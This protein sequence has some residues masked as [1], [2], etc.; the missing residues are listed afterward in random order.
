MFS[1]FDHI[2]FGNPKAFYLLVLP[3]LLIFWIAW[4]Y[5]KQYA[6]LRMSSLD[7]FSA[8]GSYKGGIKTALY[9]LRILVLCLL[10]VVMARPESNLKEE[11]VTAEGIDLVMALDVSTS[12]LAEDFKPNRLV[13]AKELAAD[14]ISNRPNDRVGLVVFAGESFT[15]CPITTD[16]QIVLSLLKEI[17]E[18]LIEDGTAIGMGLATAVSR[19]KESEAKSKVVILLTDGVN[20][21]GFID[22]MTASEAALSYGVRVYTIG[23]GT[24]GT[25]RHPMSP[26][27]PIEVKI[28]EALLKEIANMTGGRYFRA[29]NNES[30]KQIYDEIDTLE[31][32]K[33]EVSTIQRVS[34]E[35]YPILLIAGIMLLLEMI[36][37][38]TFLRSIP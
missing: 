5:N 28:D 20:N 12:M 11:N 1:Y 19:L 36:L 4:R 2:T 7:G 27:M 17:K 38:Y 33:I 6:E 9:L 24:I 32:T 3:V 25:A 37:R 8:G 18:G 16:R 29:T 35:F 31:K 15:Q 21:T 23:V 30:L 10:I 26:G 13:A 14:F 22:P 34:L